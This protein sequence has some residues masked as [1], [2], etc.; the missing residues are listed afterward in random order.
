[1][2]SGVNPSTTLREQHAPGVRGHGTSD[3]ICTKLGLERGE[4]FHQERRQETIFSER[5]QILL[6]Q[7]IDVGLRVLVDY[8]V[9]D[10]DRSSFVGSTNPI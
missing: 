5:E 10:D 3:R 4:M 8:T 2:D 9:R 7:R 6:V 1:M